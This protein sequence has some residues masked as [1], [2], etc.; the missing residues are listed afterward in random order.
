MVRVAELP[1]SARK[2][3]KVLPKNEDFSPD[4]VV[5]NSDLASEFVGK[6][7]S[8][9]GQ[10]LAFALGGEKTHA[11]SKRSGIPDST[12][13]K[14][15]AG[16][17]PGLDNLL[18]IAANLNVT[19]DW[20]AMERGPMRPDETNGFGLTLDPS[21]GRTQTILMPG[22][23]RLVPRMDVEVSAGM[24]SLVDHVDE[25]G[26]VAFRA[27]WLQRRGINPQ[28]AH[29]LT[30]RGDSMEPTIRDGDDLLVDTS[31]DRV[32]DNAIYVLVFAGRTLVKRIQMLRDG[33]I[34]IKSDNKENF[35]D[36]HVPANEVPDIKVAGRVVW[37]GRSI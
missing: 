4:Q 3:L 23:W 16:T 24:G 19:L 5:M 7:G 15:L 10:R 28:F 32:E 34:I 36:E 13:R 31:I 11:F 14:Y 6:S 1:N 18:T 20:L 12:L 29:V 37:Y 8:T 30:V 22:E 17:M 27:N 25:L 33:S 21:D 26:D 35:E 2:Q 9:F